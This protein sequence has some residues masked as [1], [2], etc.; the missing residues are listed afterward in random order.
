MLRESRASEFVER[1]R[2]F[3]ARPGTVYAGELVA[4]CAGFRQA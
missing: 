1:G 4:T 3:I 2:R